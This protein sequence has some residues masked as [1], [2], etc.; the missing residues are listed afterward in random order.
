MIFNPLALLPS[1]TPSRYR[2][3][4][5]KLAAKA[6]TSF[7]AAVEL[8]CIECC[9]WERTEAKACQVGSCPL[10]ALNRKIFT[11]QERKVQ[12]EAA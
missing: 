1:D 7:R 9:A 10:F 11:V 3:R 2:K 6:D 5:E 8:K 4:W 12:R